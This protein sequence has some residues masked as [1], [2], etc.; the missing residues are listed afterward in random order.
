[1]ECFI[2]K[3]FL[4]GQ[5][6]IDVYERA[7]CDVHLNNEVVEC[8]SCAGFTSTDNPLP[9]GLYLFNLCG[10]KVIKPGDWCE[11]LKKNAINSLVSVGFS[12]LNIKDFTIEIVTA[13]KLAEFNKDMNNR[14][15]VISSE[16][17]GVLTR[18]KFIHNIY[19]LTH[20]NSVEFEGS[21]A[22]LMLHAWQIQNNIN[23][24]PKM[25]EG[26]CNLGCYLIWI[27]MASSLAKIYLH[28]IHENPCPIYGDGF[29][30]MFE[31][32]EEFGWAELIKAVRQIT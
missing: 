27:K 28:N 16:S 2:C 12:D 22:H 31:M 21:L 26:L 13:Q 30:E 15:I 17:R 24:S 20:L 23:M 10:Y 3:K 14:G 1:M 11:H 25:T 9:D 29:R 8:S 4:L 6:Y 5:Y 19:M 18:R 7:I 32:Y